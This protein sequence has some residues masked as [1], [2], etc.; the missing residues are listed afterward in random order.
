MDEREPP[1]S[2][3]AGEKVRGHPSPR[4][5]QP[6]RPCGSLTDEAAAECLAACDDF[7]QKYEDL[8]P[9]R[10]RAARSL[11]ALPPHLPARPSP[12]CVGSALRHEGRF[13][14]GSRADAGRSRAALR[15]SYRYVRRA[16][17]AERGGRE[18]GRRRTDE[19]GPALPS[20]G[21]GAAQPGPG[22]P[23][24]RREPR[25]SPRVLRAGGLRWALTAAGRAEGARG[26]EAAGCAA[27]QSVRCD[28]AISAG[29]R[30]LRCVCLE[31]TA[32]TYALPLWCVRIAFLRDGWK[33]TWR[34]TGRERQPCCVCLCVRVRSTCR[35]AV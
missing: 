33:G 17:T 21:S 24:G 34:N 27:A 14:P 18:R 35:S 12:P 13:A 25:K 29:V 23:R 1:R 30:D 6:A 2:D 20:G 31:V 11:R 32:G 26:A 5:P 15:P 16:G 8:L 10:G 9:R 4:V 19:P 3:R 28:N 22:A 7:A